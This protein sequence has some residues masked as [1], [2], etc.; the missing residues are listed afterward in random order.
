[1][2]TDFVSS[3]FSPT[4]SNFTFL[5]LLCLACVRNCGISFFG[6]QVSVGRLL[7]VR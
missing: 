3:R 2:A 6:I 1:M 5:L 4:P 7:C